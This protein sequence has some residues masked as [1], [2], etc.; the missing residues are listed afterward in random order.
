MIFFLFSIL[1]YCIGSIN[2]AILFFMFL[3]K[4]DPR[5]RFSG[6]PGVT[7][8]YR[9]SG[10]IAAA[11]V[12]ILDV[13]RAAAVAMAASIF[14][15]PPEVAWTGMALLLGNRY[16]C[17]HQFKGGKG[18]ATYLGFSIV[19]V[20]AGALLSCLAWVVVFLLLRVPFIASFFMVAV[21]AGT[22]IV[23]WVNFPIAIVGAVCSGLFIVFNHSRNIAEFA[24]SWK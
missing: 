24:S 4:E 9:Q 22:T 1:A 14:F 18:V 17:F 13:A 10:W 2:F 8:V 21:L 16:P 5:A 6:N 12:L 7:N 15:S 11:I 19:I 23:M 3:K 20:P